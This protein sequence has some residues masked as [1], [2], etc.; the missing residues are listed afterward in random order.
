MLLLTLSLVLLDYQ[1]DFH[2]TMLLLLF[3]GK[4]VA[5]KIILTAQMSPYCAYTVVTAMLFLIMSNN[6]ILSL[7]ICNDST[8]GN[9]PIDDLR[10][11]W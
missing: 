10:A 5:L 6:R 8:D 9:V 2:H 3:W 1:E 11:R 4:E 7:T